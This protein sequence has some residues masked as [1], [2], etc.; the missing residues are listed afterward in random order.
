[1]REDQDQSETPQLC[2]T[3]CAF[4]GNPKTRNLCS[5]CYKTVIKKEASEYT[6]QQAS[7]HTTLA[8]HV[9]DKS[10]LKTNNSV[11]VKKRNRCQVCNKRAGLVPFEC[12]CGRTFCR[13]HR[14]PEV[15]ACEFDFKAA[16]RV[17]LHKENP[18]CVVDKLETRI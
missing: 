17:V 11:D 10:Q 18:V 12:R 5:V 9:A 14:M 15:H 13:L 1:M 4:F 8:V 2:K 3:C 7:E 6:T 16:G